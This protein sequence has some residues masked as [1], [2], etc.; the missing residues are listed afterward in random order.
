MR[1]RL[2]PELL[3]ADTG[4]GP[5]ALQHLARRLRAADV[6][7]VVLGIPVS[8]LEVLDLRG[9]RLGPSDVAALGAALATRGSGVEFW[10]SKRSKYHPT[11][12]KMSKT[13]SGVFIAR[14]LYC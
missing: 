10:G 11:P 8:A 9:N 2:P 1:G 13:L 14:V 6:F 7:D 12:P 3:L 5:G 4:L